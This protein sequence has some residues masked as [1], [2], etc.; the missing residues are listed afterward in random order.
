MIRSICRQTIYYSLTRIRNL[1]IS[2]V[3]III[4]ILNTT[5]VRRLRRISL[6][7]PNIYFPNNFPPSNDLLRIMT[8]KSRA[9]QEI[10]W[11]QSGL[12]AIPSI[13]NQLH[14]SLGIRQIQRNYHMFDWHSRTYCKA[15]EISTT[16]RRNMNNSM[17]LLK[18]QRNRR[19]N[20]RNHK[21]S[22]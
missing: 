9:S 11:Y 13:G 22:I 6:L 18:S 21:E 16:Q 19:P 17:W 2:I 4:A 3:L 8:Q 15:F 14:K 12:L 20:Y 1:L 10:K 7:L 5:I